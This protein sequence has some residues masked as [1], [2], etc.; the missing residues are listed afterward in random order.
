MAR[1][2]EAAAGLVVLDEAIN[3]ALSSPEAPIVLA[4]RRLG[5][6]IAESVAPGNPYLGLMLPSSPLHH[7]IARDFGHPLVATSGNLGEEPICI[8]ELEALS[9]LRGIADLFLVHDR[10]IARH[11]DDSVAWIVLGKPRLLRRARGYAPLPLELGASGPTILG[12][13]AQQKNCVALSL[14]D[15]VFVSQHLGDLGKAE[16]ADCFERA[17]ADL[18]SLYGAELEAIACDLNPDYLSSQWALSPD[19]GQGAKKPVL[20]GVQHHH[21]HMAACLAE[22]REAGKALGVIWDGSGYGGDGTVWG[23]EFLSG[24]AK[25]FFRLGH[26]APFRLLG[27]EAAV[28]EPRRSGLA[29][30]WELYGEELFEKKD[31]PLVS[32]LTK[33][34]KRAFE[35]MLRGGA[36]SPWTTSAGR[37]FDGVAAIL[38]LGKSL[39]YEG[40]AAMALEF[41]A[42]PSEESAYPFGLV[43]EDE[44]FILDWKPIVEAIVAD[45][46][47][48]RER[49]LVSARFH[50]S[51]A[52]AIVAAADRAG[53]EA[54]ALS[55]GCFQN[56]RLL[57]ATA[58]GLEQRGHRVLLHE[59]FPPNDGCI[60][61]GQVVVA[62]EL[63]RSS[64]AWSVV[65]EEAS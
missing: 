40:E 65:G 22:H 5:A 19:R 3:V 16:A 23:G 13:G 29:L 53:E 8:D 37:L 14:G 43:A 20:I 46:R 25:G 27:G 44:G 52:A 31:L 58:K 35:G 24:D 4:P 21:A 1:D 39:S 55:G 59:R 51:L 60:A 64:R 10:P 33:E 18:T 26:L 34:E 12:V 11:A 17:I 42:L 38:G 15:Q 41:A 57:E 48:G 6:P 63:L 61:L 9:R 47:E 30:L 36:F 62:S 28:R 56:R 50:A 32:A 2:L 7:L 49:G 54:V 45:L